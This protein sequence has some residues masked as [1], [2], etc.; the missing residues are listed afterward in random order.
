MKQ[1]KELAD[2]YRERAERLR[3][4]AENIDDPKARAMLLEVADDYDKLAEKTGFKPVHRNPALC[5]PL[6]Y[7]ALQENQFRLCSPWLETF[8]G[9]LWPRTDCDP[10]IAAGYPR[11]AR[12]TF[13]YG[14][15]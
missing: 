1:G 12:A 3:R 8:G 9:K 6:A 15:P 5:V 14:S 7:R 10:Q 13:L 4:I 11:R 2:S